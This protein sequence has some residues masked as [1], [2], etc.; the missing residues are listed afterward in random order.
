MNNRSITAEITQKFPLNNVSTNIVSGGDSTVFND[1]DEVGRS[2]PDDQ[3][4][5][6]EQTFYLK[7]NCYKARLKL[8]EK[9]MLF[10]E[11]Y[12]KIVFAMKQSKSGKHNGVDS[13][14]FSWC[15][16]HFK[17]DNTTGNE[18]LVSLR[19]DRRIIFIESCF[20]LLKSIH[21]KNRSWWMGQNAI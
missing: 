2:N 21:E 18:M 9:A 19:D 16:K 7:L 4:S 12:Q 11:Y 15:R 14:F 8:S 17:L 10:L 1:V 20:A 5:H 6:E 3:S 13:K